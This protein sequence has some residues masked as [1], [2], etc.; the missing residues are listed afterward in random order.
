MEFNPNDY[1]KT[2]FAFKTNEELIYAIRGFKNEMEQLKNI[3]DHPY[4]EDTDTINPDHPNYDYR[5]SY[6]RTGLRLA[7]E[8]LNKQGG[9]YE[10]TQEELRAQDFEDNIP[11]INK[12]VLKFTTLVHFDQ[13]CTATLKDDNF[14]LKIDV[15]FMP[16]S[17]D[18]ADNFYD[19]VSKQE[20]LKTI[21]NLHIGEWRTNYSLSR[22]GYPDCE[23]SQWD[24]EIYFSNNHLPVRIHGAGAKP[25]DFYGLESIFNIER[26]N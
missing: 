23:D 1:F 14:Y 5:L 15:S 26:D 7:K 24:L 13:T 20:F 21:S 22:F 25:Y 2:E 11:F 9:T 3:L 8:I 12:I 16:K 18:S 19:V 6:I 17:S 10:P 4:Y